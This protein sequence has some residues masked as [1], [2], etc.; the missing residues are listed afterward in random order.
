MS[1]MQKAHRNGIGAIGQNPLVPKDESTIHASARTTTGSTRNRIQS[2]LLFRTVQHAVHRGQGL[3]QTGKSGRTRRHSGCRGEGVL[4]FNTNAA[5]RESFAVRMTLHV[6]VAT[7]M[8]TPKR[9]ILA[10]AKDVPELLNQLLDLS[11]FGKG[12]FPISV[13]QNEK[14]YT[15]LNTSTSDRKESANRTVVFVFSPY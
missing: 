14:E 7:R 15:P 3:D 5:I 1:S 11:I 4:S 8:R 9:R 12:L 13:T 6:P 10:A 2:I